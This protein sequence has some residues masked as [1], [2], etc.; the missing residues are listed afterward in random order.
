MSEGPTRIGEEMHTM[1]AGYVAS[2]ATLLA[3]AMKLADGIGDEPLKAAILHAS[4]ELLNARRV[5]FDG[6]TRMRA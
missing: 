3:A 6:K 2:A 5:N 1:I 4:N